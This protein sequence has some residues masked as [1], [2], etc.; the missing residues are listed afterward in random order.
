[1]F[2]TPERLDRDNSWYCGRCKEHRQALK[3]VKLW[4]LPEVLIMTLKRF[5]VR[6]GAVLSG[7]GLGVNVKIDAPVDFPVTGLDASAFVHEGAPL[8]SGCMYDLFAV[9]NHFGR[10]GSGH[11]TAYARS[12]AGDALSSQWHCFDDD[13]VTPCTERDVRANSRASYILFYRRTPPPVT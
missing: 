6:T 8:R 13:S 12:W 4:R 1:M 2:T 7:L 11:Y 5:E 10:M 3:T 9:C